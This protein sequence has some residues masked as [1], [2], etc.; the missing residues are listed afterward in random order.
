MIAELM[1][2]IGM[3]LFTLLVIVGFRVFI[4]SNKID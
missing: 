3:T 2:E 1:I 4:V